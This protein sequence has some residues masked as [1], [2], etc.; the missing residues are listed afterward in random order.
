MQKAKAVVCIKA[1]AL[2]TVMAEMTKMLKETVVDKPNLLS[3][4]PDLS[5]SYHKYVELCDE[6]TVYD[7]DESEGTELT[8]I[9]SLY[10]GL[11]T[12][13]NK[14]K[15]VETTS[16]NATIAGLP[17]ANSTF[18]EKQKLLRLPLAQPPAFNGDY[19]KWLSYKNS[20]LSM[21]DAR[22]DIDDAVKFMYLRESIEGNALRKIAI[23]DISGENYAKAWKTLDASYDKKRVIMSKHLDAILDTPIAKEAS[24]QELTDLVD[25]IKQHLSS[26]D[27]LKIPADQRDS[28]LLIRI[29]ERSLPL[30]L[31]QQW[32][33]KVGMDGVPSLTQI[34]DFIDVNISLCSTSDFGSMV[35]PT[36]RLDKPSTENSRPSK[37]RKGNDSKR[38]LVTNVDEHCAKCK[39]PHQL[40]QCREFKELTVS[41]RW[42]V[43][44]EHK[45]CFNCLRQHK[46]K[47]TMG[48]C[49]RCEKYHN[50]L[51]HSD[52]N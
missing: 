14:F 29:L 11:V 16:L 42:S 50:T 35:E 18:I 41:D 49:K 4:L 21:I 32:D 34:Y 20:F 2:K 48:H 7:K 8:E 3:R 38:V 13:I 25:E 19:S 44:R 6:L 36:A 10:Y 33:K 47:C 31:R 1:K 24:S 45:L 22:T 30:A 52:P 39:G 37:F 17:A 46:D 9:R 28:R 27:S 26:L 15:P 5:A 51:L 43:A 12:E 40:F 23:Y